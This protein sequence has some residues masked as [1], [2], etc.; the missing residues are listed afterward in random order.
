MSPKLVL[1]YFDIG[2]A[3]EPIRWALEQGG[4]EWEDK[5]L[6]REEFG[7]LKPSEC[8]CPSQDEAMGSTQ[9][10]RTII[11]AI[12]REGSFVPYVVLSNMFAKLSLTVYRRA[13][14]IERRYW[15]REVDRSKGTLRHAFLSG[16][17]VRCWLRIR[18]IHPIQSTSFN[19]KCR[20]TA[21]ISHARTVDPAA[22]IC[23]ELFG[24]ISV[25]EL[26]LRSCPCFHEVYSLCAINILKAPVCAVCRVSQIC[27]C[28]DRFLCSFG[29][30]FSFLLYSYTPMCR[31]ISSFASVRLER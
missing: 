30:Y 13:H 22:L 6:S 26:M 10:L 23:F 18:R 7:A 8:G 14:R 20:Y 15:L 12:L 31:D 2:G 25:P 28:H 19:S 24:C 29:C 5:R 9:A 11:D 17:S 3:A 1:T 16:C 4:L 27:F 21:R